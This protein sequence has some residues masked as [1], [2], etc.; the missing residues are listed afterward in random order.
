[1]VE[2][3]G[4]VLNVRS[5]KAQVRLERKRECKT[6]GG[7]L[8][9]ETE[10]FMIA[11]AEDGVGVLPGDAVRVS[12]RTS[13]AKA[14]LLLYLLPLILFVAGFLGGA[15]LAGAW[16]A[17]GTEGWGIAAGL[18]AMALSYYVLFRTQ[19]RSPGKVAGLMKISRVV[20]R[21]ESAA[22]G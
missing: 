18:A 4:I 22:P 19:R 20:S 13:A 12:N 21:G 11:E 9:S 10:G 8:F 14:A 15:A 5:G 17:R 7:C 1:M 16:G 2:E 6:C 3:T